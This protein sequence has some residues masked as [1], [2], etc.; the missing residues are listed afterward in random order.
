MADGIAAYQADQAA[1]Q[2]QAYDNV[3]NLGGIQIHPD[4]AKLW[5]LG[6]W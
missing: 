2:Q 6:G 5:A 4:L 1:K 3:V